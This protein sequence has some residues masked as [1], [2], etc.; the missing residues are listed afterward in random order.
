MV[1]SWVTDFIVRMRGEHFFSAAIYSR[2]HECGGVGVGEERWEVR[3]A[4][5]SSVADAR[6]RVRGLV[7][8]VVAGLW[9]LLLNPARAS[10]ALHGPSLAYPTLELVCVHIHR[11][12]LPPVTQRLALRA[13]DQSAALASHEIDFVDTRV[14][15]GNKGWTADASY[16]I[17]MDRSLVVVEKSL[18]L[19]V[20][21]ELLSQGQRDCGLASLAMQR[22]AQREERG[23][24]EGGEEIGAQ[25]IHTQ[26]VAAGERKHRGRRSRADDAVSRDRLYEARG[27]G[28]DSDSSEQRRLSGSLE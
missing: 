19:F 23:V 7:A 20:G 10:R 14:G 1:D 24:C 21:E 3:T 12:A 13:E 15:E 6:D 11:T 25:I 9:V 8:H 17:S 5:V 16:A 4:E 18:I 2:A 26:R 28:T 27:W 22:T